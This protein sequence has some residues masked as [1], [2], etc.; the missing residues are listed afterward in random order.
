M[1]NFAVIGLTALA[2][3]IVGCNKEEQPTMSAP[4]EENS[5]V[6]SSTETSLLETQEMAE[7]NSDSAMES[8]DHNDQ[9]TTEDSAALAQSMEQETAQAAAAENQE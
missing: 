2:L 4:A 6:S 1:R 8:L 7:M 3:S 9:E 5:A